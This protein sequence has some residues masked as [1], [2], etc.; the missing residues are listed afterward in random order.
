MTELIVVIV[1]WAVLYKQDFAKIELI[2]D[3]W[4]AWYSWW[5]KFLIHI[6]PAICVVLNTAITRGVLIPGHALYMVV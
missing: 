1:Y 5:H 6:I 3:P 2:K 4:F